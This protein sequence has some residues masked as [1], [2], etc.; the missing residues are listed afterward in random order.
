MLSRETSPPSEHGPE[1]KLA[2]W[3]VPT[4]YGQGLRG[5][6][7]T[8]LREKRVVLWAIVSAQLHMGRADT[9]G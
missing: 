2:D 4:A 3:T 9:G 7:Q 6:S 1:P 8:C 5:H